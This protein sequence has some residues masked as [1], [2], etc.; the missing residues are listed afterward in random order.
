MHRFRWASDPKFYSDPP[1]LLICSGNCKVAHTFPK[2]LVLKL[3]WLQLFIFL[4]YIA[5]TFILESSIRRQQTV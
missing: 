4:K 2:F 5:V 1:R 3:G